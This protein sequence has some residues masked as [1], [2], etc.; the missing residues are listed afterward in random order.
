MKREKTQFFN[1]FLKFYKIFFSCLL[2]FSLGAA[3]FYALKSNY[4]DSFEILRGTIIF[5]ILLWCGYNIHRLEAML[6]TKS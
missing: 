4:N 5:V 2:I 6:K 1:A 3:G